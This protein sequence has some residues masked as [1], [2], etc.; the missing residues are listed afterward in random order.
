MAGQEQVTANQRVDKIAGRVKM[1][2]LVFLTLYLAFWSAQITW[3]LLD[4]TNSGASKVV[5]PEHTVKTQSAVSRKVANLANYHIF[6][7]EGLKPAVKK[8]QVKSAPKT[9]LRLMLKGVFTGELGGESGAIIEEIGRT[10]E[11]YRVGDKVP[12]N[13]TLETVLSDRVLLNRNGRLETLA[14]E[15]GKSSGTS[16]AQVARPSRQ[17]PSIQSPE[18]FLEVAT[19]RLSQDPEGALRSVGLAANEGGGYVYQGKNP[20]LSGLNLQKGDVILSV[21]GNTLGDLQKDKALMKSLYEQGNLE[22]EVVRNGASFYINYPL[23]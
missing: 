9:T 8:E 6:G 7:K 21:N 17:K 15:Q 23:R 14:F 16:I 19:E 4:D 2:L 13:A 20:M 10:T 11:Y 3:F 12:G 18:E 1:L 5:L 22:V